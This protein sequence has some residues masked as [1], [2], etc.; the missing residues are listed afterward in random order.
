MEITF[1]AEG[2]HSLVDGIQGILY[3]KSA[4]KLPADLD[5]LTYLSE[6]SAA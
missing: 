2:C 4:A 5:F 3:R 6:F 1:Y